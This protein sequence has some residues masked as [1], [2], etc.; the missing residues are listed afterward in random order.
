MGGDLHAQI[1]HG[2]KLP[3]S[4]VLEEGLI[5]P[6]IFE[7]DNDQLISEPEYRDKIIEKCVSSVI[8][9]SLLADKKWNIYILNSSQDGDLDDGYFFL[10][11]VSQELYC[12]RFPDFVTGDFDDM[13]FGNTILPKELKNIKLS[14]PYLW[15]YKTHWVIE[16]SW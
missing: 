14:S 5:I 16:S 10:Y 3:L 11:D 4:V 12:G 13:L 15:E 9:Q 7:D 1:I 2:F 8:L 6:E